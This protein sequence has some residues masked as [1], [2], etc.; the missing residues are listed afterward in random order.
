MQEF[1][2]PQAHAELTDEQTEAEVD[3]RGGHRQPAQVSRGQSENEQQDAENG[4][5]FEK[6]HQVVRW[7]G[8]TCARGVCAIGAD[9]DGRVRRRCRGKPPPVRAAAWALLTQPSDDLEGAVA[10]R[11]FVEI[12][13]EDQLVGLG[14]LEQYVEA[15]ANLL[16]AA[17]QRQAEEVAHRLLF[18]R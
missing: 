13:G 14:L 9:G 2:L 11:G 7:R 15:R 4:H 8:A 12:A 3:Q 18:M 5:P 6:I 10:V 1:H 17:D 16:R